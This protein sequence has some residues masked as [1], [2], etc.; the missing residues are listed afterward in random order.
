MSIRFEASR[1]KPAA[2]KADGETVG[3]CVNMD[4][5]GLMSKFC[6]VEICEY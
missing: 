1:L 2:T 6:T 3:F 5:S 4:F